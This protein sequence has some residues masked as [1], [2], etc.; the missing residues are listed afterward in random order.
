M[1]KVYAENGRNYGGRKTVAGDGRRNSAK[2]KNF[3]GPT[4]TEKQFA[5]NNRK[6]RAT[7]TG[8]NPRV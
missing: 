3:M 5:K 1:L 4:I 8:G 7:K 6:Q 2:N